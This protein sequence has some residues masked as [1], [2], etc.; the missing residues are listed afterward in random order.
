[1]YVYTV[2]R[3]RKPAGQN[4]RIIKFGIYLSEH[5]Q[6][7]SVKIPERKDTHTQLFFENKLFKCDCPRP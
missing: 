1:M 5:R 3:K 4:D 2:Q 7:L 6:Q